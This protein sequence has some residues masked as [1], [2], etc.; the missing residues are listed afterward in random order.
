MCTMSDSLKMAWEGKKLNLREEEK[1]L[2]DK[3]MVK[4]DGNKFTSLLSEIGLLEPGMSLEEKREL[5]SVVLESTKMAQDQLSQREK[6]DEWEL[7][8][9]SEEDTKDRAGTS[10]RKVHA[11]KGSVSSTDKD[12]A[13]SVGLKNTNS[14]RDKSHM[15]KE[16]GVGNETGKEKDDSRVTAEMEQLSTVVKDRK[17]RE[18]TT[19][20]EKRDRQRKA[21]EEARRERQMKGKE[22][23]RERRQRERR[24]GDNRT[25]KDV[26]VIDDERKERAPR[27]AGKPSC[28]LEELEKSDVEHK[29][30]KGEIPKS[31]FY[32]PAHLIE[33][34]PNPF[35][36]EIYSTTVKRH[37]PKNN[38]LLKLVEEDMRNKLAE[39]AI[40]GKVCKESKEIVITQEER[41]TAEKE[42]ANHMKESV[43]THGEHCSTRSHGNGRRQKDNKGEDGESATKDDRLSIFPK[44]E[45]ESVKD[46]S[47]TRTRR[48]LS[49]ALSSQSSVSVVKTQ[50]EDISC[51]KRR[52]EE[53]IND[54]SLAPQGDGF[55]KE[56]E[57]FSNSDVKTPD[58]KKRRLEKAQ[59][60]RKWS[61][62]AAGKKMDLPEKAHEVENSA[63]TKS[64]KLMPNKRWRRVRRNFKSSFGSGSEVD[65]WISSDEDKKVEPKLLTKDQIVARFDNC[66][67]RMKNAIQKQQSS[68]LQD[69][70]KRV[71]N[72][73]C[74]K[75]KYKVPPGFQEPDSDDDF[76]LWKICFGDKLATGG[77]SESEEIK[78]D[79]PVASKSIVTRSRARQRNSISPSLSSKSVSSLEERGASSPLRMSPLKEI[80]PGPSTQTNDEIQST[81]KSPSSKEMD[82]ISKVAC[83]TS[84]ISRSTQTPR[85]S[86]SESDQSNS[87]A[88]APPSTISNEEPEECKPSWDLYEVEEEKKDD[89]VELVDLSSGDGCKSDS[90]NCPICNRAFPM[91]EI[92]AHASVCN[93]EEDDS[94]EGE[95]F[96]DPRIRRENLRSQRMLSKTTGGEKR[97]DDAGS[98]EILTDN[99]E[100]EEKCENKRE[101]RRNRKGRGIRKGGMK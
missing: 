22:E 10:K 36:T 77:R 24:K 48:M 79:T 62:V 4:L 32:G 33:T 23:E 58:E 2:D 49:L 61:D 6:E 42:A 82:L 51:E 59:L 20:R 45:L 71:K 95:P 53:E 34:N 35:S 93:A 5:A 46:G 99:N 44:R 92:E 11:D 3:L 80:M 38:N 83:P 28:L 85:E 1:F 76:N 50:E 100:K 29:K 64:N 88:T 72:H 66:L 41:S 40:K 9:L 81:S 47:R 65:E 84:T 12:R 101:K 39:A 25:A 43:I 16:D 37:H 31:S 54:L 86:D 8:V 27:I 60:S 63:E 70:S 15:L 87:T 98:R 96:V 57:G 13:S 18:M 52:R 17:E 90:I 67:L 91:A 30:E 68:E 19:K 97:G 14:Q 55:E 94:S 75:K 7:M 26:V 69:K 74:L 78:S 73:V 21:E 56:G 89:D